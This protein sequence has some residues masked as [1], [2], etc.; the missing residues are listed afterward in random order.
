MF[1]IYLDS[2]VNQPVHAEAFSVHLEHERFESSQIAAL[3][4]ADR[5]L[6]AERAIV[7]WAERVRHTRSVREP[8]AR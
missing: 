8:L 5:A 4:R 3:R 2:T 1:R 7:Q 6:S